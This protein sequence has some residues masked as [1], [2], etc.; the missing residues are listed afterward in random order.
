M[1]LKDGR[2]TILTSDTGV[3]I[4][5]HDYDASVT[6]VKVVLT[7]EQFTQALSRLAYT[8]CQEIEVIALDK[9]GKKHENKTLKF[10]IPESLS[11]AYNRTDPTELIDLALKVCP[12]GWRPD[13][14]FSSQNSFFKTRGKYY[15]RTI[16]RRWVQPRKGD[17]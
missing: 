17:I 11:W 16:I 1:I 6:F 5:L 15:A 4:E 7:S 13:F 8:K 12:A 10:E 9:I 3:T 2:I 14:S